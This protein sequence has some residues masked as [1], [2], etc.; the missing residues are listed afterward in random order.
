MM[1]TGDFMAK[2]FMRGW[3]I[4]YDGYDWR[5]SDNNKL[6]DDSRLC[7]KCGRYPT[8]EGYDACLGHIKGAIYACCGHGVEVPYIL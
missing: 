2:S 6:A 5:Y 4:Y 3:E 1:K 8:K 7:K